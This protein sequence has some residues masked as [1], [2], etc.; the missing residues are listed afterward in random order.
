MVILNDFFMGIEG[1]FIL[2][3]HSNQV[4]PI[5]W[6]ENLRHYAIFVGLNWT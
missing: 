3:H 6:Y 4:I 1:V 5:F 2:V